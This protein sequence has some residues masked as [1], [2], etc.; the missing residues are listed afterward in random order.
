MEGD[1]KIYMT[2]TPV[3][4]W[5][6][7]NALAI[8]TLCVTGAQIRFPDYVSALG[9]YRAAVRLHNAAGLV[10]TASFA[11]WLGYYLFVGRNLLRLYVPRRSDL[12]DGLLRQARYYGYGYFLGRANPHSASPDNKFNPLQK[13]AYL[14]MM[15]VLV[16]LTI[17]TGVLMLKLGPLQELV[18]LAGGIRL[19][20]GA[21]FLLACALC[22]F[23]CTHVY[24]ATLGRT[25]LEHFKPM[26]TG[27][28]QAHA[29]PEGAE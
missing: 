15:L 29:R 26:W 25:P 20:T 14:A 17:G 4:I 11:V 2:P 1:G 8:I 5:H 13:A 12:R 22:A 3:R 28:E 27:W 23:L 9:S 18:L 10:S 6:W 24:L 16:P 21:H 19:V 7:V